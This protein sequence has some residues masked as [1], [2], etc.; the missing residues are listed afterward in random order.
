VPERGSALFKKCQFLSKASMQLA[1][2]DS[3]SLSHL[4]LI[5]RDGPPNINRQN[6]NKNIN[7]KSLKSCII[8]KVEEG[9]S[10]G[11]FDVKCMDVPIAGKEQAINQH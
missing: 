10:N 9:R 2:P 4:R 7:R 8:Q 3:A 1:H 6:S 5:D 11:R